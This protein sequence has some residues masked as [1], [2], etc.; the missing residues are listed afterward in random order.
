M[1]PMVPLPMSTAD[2]SRSRA[3]FLARAC[4]VFNGFILAN[5]MLGALVRAH[6]AGLACPDW[7][8]CFGDVIPR[9]DFKVAWEVSHRYVGWTFGVAYLALGFGVLRD[10]ALRRAAGAVWGVGIALLVLQGLLGAL[11][12]WQLLASWSVTSHL[13]VGNA[14]NACVLWL[15]L[16]LHRFAAGAPHP[17]V[18]RLAKLAVA[19]AALFLGFQVALG[20]LVSSRYAGLACSKWPSCYDDEWFPAWG[21][22]NLVGLHVHHR[23]NGYLLAAFVGWMAW[24]ARHLP[25]LAGRARIALALVF[26]QMGIGITNVLLQLPVEITAL[27]TLFAGA[28]ALTLTSCAHAA[29]AKEPR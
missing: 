18:P 14:W 8:L 24:E 4:F 6:G 13:V 5:I 22:D 3:A 7:P 17:A 15:G 25:A 20:G 11:T 10:A 1:R 28:L 12:V 21:M 29:F 19:L 9:F 26:V 27:H 16:A 23:A 2:E